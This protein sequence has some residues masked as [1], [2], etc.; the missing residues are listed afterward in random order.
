MTHIATPS[1]S[2][3]LGALV[4]GAIGIA[5]SL[6]AQDVKVNA[7]VDVW[8][9]QA[10]DSN[11]RT[12][13][14]AKYY[15]LNS[16]FQEN[17][18]TVRRAEIYIS[19]KV[20]DEL[21]YSVVFDPNIATPTA[22]NVLH[23]AFITYKPNGWFSLQVGQFKPLQTYEATLVGAKDLL[24][25]DRSQ[26]A[27]VIGDKRD[28]GA[29]AGFAFGKADE[30]SGKF[31]VGFTNGTTDK[32]G[33]K[34]VD[35][36]AQKDFVARLEFNYGKT[37]KFGVYTRQGVTDAKDVNL[38]ANAFSYAGTSGPSIQEIQDNKDK[39]TNLGGYYAFENE[40]WIAQAEVVT[41]LLTSIS[42][43]RHCRRG[44]HGQPRWP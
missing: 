37:Q 38:T 5:P 22:P 26:L 33:G 16:A 32:D 18:F 4:V 44:H 7:L 29:V 28:R 21:S 9:T 23:D 36:N 17:T 8:Y 3:I 14:P 20:T 34:S 25:Y 40:T 35:S 12:N 41:G 1:S 39:T 2:R 11:L 15:S 10:L 30:F 13:T 19:G 31:S 24:F 43:R 27:R 6:Q 42:L